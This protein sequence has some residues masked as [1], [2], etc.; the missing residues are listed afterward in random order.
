MHPFNNSTYFAYDFHFY[1]FSFTAKS[2]VLYFELK[3]G[4]NL[5]SNNWSYSYY[6]QYPKGDFGYNDELT[7]SKIGPQ[8]YSIRFNPVE[9]GVEPQP[10][11]ISGLEKDFNYKVTNGPKTTDISKKIVLPILE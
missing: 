4:Y 8:L 7:M 5:I 10:E 6:N 9:T 3:D 1:D 11:G 2:I